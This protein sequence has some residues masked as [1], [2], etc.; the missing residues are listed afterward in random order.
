MV[1]DRTYVLIPA[2]VGCVN[3]RCRSIG[4]AAWQVW[5]R[6]N[7]GLGSWVMA[8]GCAYAECRVC[9]GWSGKQCPAGAP[10]P[11]APLPAVGRQIFTTV[12]DNQTEL[13]VLVLRVSDLGS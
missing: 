6:V 4:V 5:K 11:Q 1:G 12:H 2:E 8:R 7:L 9:W 3:C 13:C 10:Y